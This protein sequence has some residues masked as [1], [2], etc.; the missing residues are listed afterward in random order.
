MA[1]K[2]LDL[3][4]G[5]GFDAPDEDDEGPTRKAKLFGREWEFRVGLPIFTILGFESEDTAGGAM[6]EFLENVVVKSQRRE[7]KRELIR[8]VKGPEQMVKL[9]DVLTEELAGNDSKSSSGSGT[10]RSK[11]S[12]AAS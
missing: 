6:R 1:I 12:S 8:R 9:L 7:W 2:N 3:K 5:D 11:K 4:L 10:G